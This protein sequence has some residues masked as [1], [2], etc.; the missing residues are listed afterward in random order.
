MS[1]TLVKEIVD[2]NRYMTLATA[3]ESG[4]PWA[5]PVWYATADYREFLW[6]SS[7][8]ARHSR[9]LAVRPD[10][11]IVIFDSRQEPGSGQ[12]VY[13]AA[14]AGLVPDSELDRAVALFSEISQSQDAPA[15]SRADVEPPARFR[16]YR[17]TAAR[18]FVLSGRDERLPVRLSRSARRA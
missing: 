1:G 16:L 2:A 10:V 9:N 7:P 8:D 6:V 14:T 12:G 13:L 3:D 11:G 5:T 17:A 18:H 4:L 15:W